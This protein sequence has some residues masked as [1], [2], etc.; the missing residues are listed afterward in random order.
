MTKK[1]QVEQE[2]EDDPAGQSN[3]GGGRRYGFWPLIALGAAALAGAL[4]TA[5]AYSKS[6]GESPESYVSMTWWGKNKKSAKNVGLGV[7]VGLGVAA[8]LVLRRR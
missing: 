8:L 5:S 1:E 2:G 3:T 6:K 4:G 7:V